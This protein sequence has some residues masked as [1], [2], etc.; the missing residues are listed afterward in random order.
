MN[1]PAGH[2]KVGHPPG[3][4]AGEIDQLYRTVEHFELER[5]RR[6]GRLR[7]GRQPRREQIFD[8]AS[9]GSHLDE[10]VAAD[11]PHRAEIA[12][13]EHEG[14]EPAFD[15]DPRHSDHRAARPIGEHDVAIF[16][17][18][19]PVP[20]GAAACRGAG[21]A[22]ERRLERPVTQIGEH[23]HARQEPHAPEQ[24]GERR[25]REDGAAPRPAAG[26][27]SGRTRLHEGEV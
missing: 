3:V 14:R 11:Q 27:V 1:H 24:H 25:E 15:H 26:R 19:E 2:R 12:R 8:R 18:A 17:P 6:P 9:S 16:D 22:G 5:H 20:G 7:E 4:A 21:D 13:I 10:G 23:E